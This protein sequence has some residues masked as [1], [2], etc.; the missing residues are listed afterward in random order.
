M[1]YVV[2]K[3]LHVLSSTV[4]FGTGVGSAWYFFVAARGR[5]PKIVAFVAH[6]LV[7][8]DWLFTATT[9]VIQPVT[10]IWLV[11]TA[12][13]AWTSRWIWLSIVLFAVAALCWFRVVV[14]Q[15]RMR[16]L[17]RAAANDNAA[18]PPEFSR[19]FREWVALGVV[20]LA[21]FVAI[22]Y[23]MVAKPA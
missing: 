22:F 6:A 23:L 16:A 3:W 19:R 5:D 14:L 20:A 12:N 10:G 11:R 18:L 15:L 2:V 21:C 4:V 7:I 8:A 17:A 13:F 1:D 9:M